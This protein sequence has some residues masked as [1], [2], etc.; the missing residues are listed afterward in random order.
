MRV[1]ICISCRPIELP[2]FDGQIVKSEP[3]HCHGRGGT[4]SIKGLIGSGFSCTCWCRNHETE[5]LLTDGSPEREN[6]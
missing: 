3:R 5:P 6:G 4:P 2:G 1:G